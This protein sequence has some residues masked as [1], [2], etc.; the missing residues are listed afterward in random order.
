M[1]CILVVS[2]LFSEIGSCIVG[3]E[4]EDMEDAMGDGAFADVCV[5][6]W[7]GLARNLDEEGQELIKKTGKFWKSGDQGAAGA[8]VAAFDPALNGRFLSLWH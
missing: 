8:L 7:T 5:A 1:L 3:G 4:C 2:S 6:I